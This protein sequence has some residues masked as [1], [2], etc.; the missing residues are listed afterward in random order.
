M[1]LLVSLSTF[2]EICHKIPDGS[3]YRKDVASYT[4]ALCWECTDSNRLITESL[5][6]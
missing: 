5:A 2:L 6:N 4:A 1:E 3:L